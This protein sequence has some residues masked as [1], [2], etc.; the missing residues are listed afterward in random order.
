MKY[1][2]CIVVLFSVNTSLLKAQVIESPLSTVVKLKSAEAICDFEAAEVYI[3]VI[4]TYAQ[5]A[6]TKTPKEE[7]KST[8]R[9]FYNLSKDK[10][11]TNTLKY[12][13][14]SIHERIEGELAEVRLVN[15]NKNGKSIFYSLEKRK[16]KWIVVGIKWEQGIPPR[17]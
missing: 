8:I 17:E 5:Y 11:F 16:N 12:H 1:F 6:E 10:K 9:F 3:D 2:I 14:Y 7:W 15:N 4:K 13:N